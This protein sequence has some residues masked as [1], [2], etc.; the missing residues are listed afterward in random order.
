[1][2]GLVKRWTILIAFAAVLQ[3]PGALLAQ[4]PEPDAKAA[5]AKPQAK[6]TQAAPTGSDATPDEIRIGNVMPYTG[7]LAAF[8]SIGRTESAYFDML[9][10][11]GG[12]NGH[13]IKFISDDSSS[14]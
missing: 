13:K 2:Q 11:H 12:I 9:N 7:A 1:M 10:A 3:L 4:Q 8:G 14:D 5:Q 6:P